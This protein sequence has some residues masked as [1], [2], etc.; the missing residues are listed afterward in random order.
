MS[1]ASVTNMRYAHFV[2]FQIILIYVQVLLS[3]TLLEECSD[4]VYAFFFIGCAKSLPVNVKPCCFA[5]CCVNWHIWWV[6]VLCHNTFIFMFH[7]L[8]KQILKCY[9]F[10]IFLFVQSVCA[11]FFAFSDFGPSDKI[12]KHCQRQ[13]GP[14]VKFSL[15]K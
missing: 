11:I 14:R 12:K 9:F 8:L 15:P 13:N 10:A 6:S 5:F 1:V 4:A 7:A 2:L 3:I